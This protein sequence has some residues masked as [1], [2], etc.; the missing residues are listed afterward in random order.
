MSRSCLVFA[1]LLPFAAG[2]GDKDGTTPPAD[3]TNTEVP[4]PGDP[5]NA[6]ADGDGAT[7][8]DGDCDD[9]DATV[10]PG[11]SEDC[12]GVDNN[13]DGRADE[14]FSDADSDTT[15]DCLDVE[16]CDGV[17][18]DGDGAADE[19]FVDSDGDGL[20][21]CVSTEVCD[22]IDNNGDGAIDEGFD[23]D[24]DGFTAC[25]DDPQDC[26]DD[27][28][29][30]NPDASEIDA[31]GVDED[32]DG[33]TDE[34]SWAEGDLVITEIMVNPSRV[35]D[36]EGEWVEL[37]NTTSRELT[38]NGLTLSS[39]GDED[40]RVQSG[41][42]ITLAPGA[43]IVIGGELVST[44]NGGVDVDAAWAGLSLK[45]S[46]GDSFA[47]KVGDLVIDE[48]AWDGG[49]TFPNPEGASLSLSPSALTSALNDIGSSWCIA[50]AAWGDETDLGSPGATNPSCDR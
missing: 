32:C 30:I 11:R 29:A 18:N 8:E 40:H 6:D 19:D 38:L 35:A 14:G 31:T 42:P 37:L 7:V 45:N 5:V 13:C 46:G 17:D 9:A 26:D 28:S 27:D 22:G 20:A 48:V 15:P 21:D 12:D 33:L 41:A 16:D 36:P 3:D 50:T 34:T 2:C 49:A 23:N 39:T 24:G 43:L 25:D 47:V 10:Y 44:D 1:L 4:D